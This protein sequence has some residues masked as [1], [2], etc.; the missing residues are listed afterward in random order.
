MINYIQK[1]QSEFLSPFTYSYKFFDNV[2]ITVM[3][4]AHTLFHLSFLIAVVRLEDALAELI[5]IFLKREAQCK[6]C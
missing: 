1:G 4:F 5:E 2:F 6:R 3:R